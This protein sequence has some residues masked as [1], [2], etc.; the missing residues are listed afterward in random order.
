V[1]EE[2]RCRRCRRSPT[3]GGVAF[4]RPDEGSGQPRQLPETFN[5][6]G[7]GGHGGRENHH[8]TV[9]VGMHLYQ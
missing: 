3:R 4:R 9:L 7:Q 8:D 6:E 1:V 5:T 2:T